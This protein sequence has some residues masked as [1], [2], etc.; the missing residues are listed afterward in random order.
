VSTASGGVATIKWV[1]RRTLYGAHISKD[2]A[3]RAFPVRISAGALAPNIP[4]RDLYVSPYHHMYF[5]G[6]LIPAMLLVNGKTIV[7]DFS[8]KMFEYF[9]LEL[10]Q[11]DIL[12]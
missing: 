5:D 4:T 8:Q 12:V 2:N 1:G 6:K 10:E 7:Q 9:H 3:I 11:F